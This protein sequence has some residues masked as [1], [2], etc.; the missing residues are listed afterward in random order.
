MSSTSFFAMFKCAEPCVDR[1]SNAE[2][3]PRW[4]TSP[5]H[6]IIDCCCKISDNLIIRY[7]CTPW[8]PLKYGFSSVVCGLKSITHFDPGAETIITKQSR[9]HQ[10]AACQHD[11]NR[12]VFTRAQHVN[13]ALT[14]HIHTPTP[15]YTPLAYPLTSATHHSHTRHTIYTSHSLRIFLISFLLRLVE[16]KYKPAILR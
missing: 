8:A 5:A 6:V 12:F 2:S 9:D 7:L 11:D 1:I 14:H 16:R 3:P 13:T 15:T 4:Q 10:S